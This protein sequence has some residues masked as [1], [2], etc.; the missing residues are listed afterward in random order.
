MT[1]AISGEMPSKLIDEFLEEYSSA[2][3]IRRYTRK[4]AGHG[5]SYLLDRDYRNIYLDALERYAQKST[6]RGVRLWEFGCGGGMNLLQLVSVIAG[7]HIPVDRAYGTDFSEALIEAAS[8]EAETHLTPV[9]REKVRFCVARNQNL[10]DDVTK[11]MNIRKEDLL[12]SFDIILGV[13]T[14]RYCHRLRNETDCVAGIFDLLTEGGVCIVIDMNNKFPLF[15]SRFRDRLTK[16][17]EACYL[18]SL[19]ALARPFVAAGFEILKQEH[20]C[21][22][23]H[24]AGSALTMTMRALT[25]LLDTLAPSRAMRS[26][27]IARKPTP[28]VA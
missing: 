15:R 25:P 24:S 4:T 3:S 17:E 2:E 12:G 11:G 10:I 27:V 23:P 6:T 18:P 22:I 8:R 14:M 16:D 5:I 7:R 21:W 9:Q 19:D 28:Q 1:N 26:L 13:N 20:F